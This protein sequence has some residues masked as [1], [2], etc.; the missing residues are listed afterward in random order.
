VGAP[1]PAEFF[2][3]LQ[4]D[5]VVRVPG[6]TGIFLTR[7]AKDMPPIIVSYV[8]Q[9]HSLHETVVALTVSFESIPR[10]RRRDRI[11]CEDLGNGFWHVT[12]H[13]G[14]VEVPD[15][16]TVISQAKEE[17][18]PAW[19]RPIY[20]IERYD[21]VSRKGRSAMS[22]WRVALFAFMSRNSAH[23]VDRFSI[24]S[25]ALVEIGRRVEL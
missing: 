4:G 12:V 22:R 16:P 20:Y 18:V 3:R 2:R 19:D 15:L 5:K 17:G 24:P 25:N 1:L 23:A 6:R 9:G 11:R 10:V 21:P 13:F 8:Q 14:F 7:F